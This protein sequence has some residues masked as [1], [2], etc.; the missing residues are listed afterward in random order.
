MKLVL[1]ELLRSSATAFR[2]N[3]IYG[4]DGDGP[5]YLTAQADELERAADVIGELFTALEDFD[6]WF[7]DFDPEK[8]SSRMEGRKVVIRARAALT[9]AQ[10]PA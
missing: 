9:K 10:D 4:Q 8:Q 6:N 3:P 7:C 5:V 1:T 2:E